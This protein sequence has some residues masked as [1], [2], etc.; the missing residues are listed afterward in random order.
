MKTNLTNPFNLYVLKLIKD[1]YYVGITQKDL[2]SRFLQHKHGIGSSWTQLYKPISIVETLMTTN[3]FDE[4]K[5]TKMYMDKYGIDN[6]RGGSYTK[7]N[8]EEYQIKALKLELCTANNLCFKCGKLGHFA[9][10]CK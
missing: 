2:F 3:K 5:L 10:R 7:I 4:D 9:S 1:K 6:V 8:L